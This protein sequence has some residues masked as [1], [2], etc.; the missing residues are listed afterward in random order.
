MFADDIK[1][2]ETI[3]DLERRES[4]YRPASQYLSEMSEKRFGFYLSSVCQQKDQGGQI[5][6]TSQF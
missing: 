1:V 5:K 6:A 2:Y 3:P 4:A